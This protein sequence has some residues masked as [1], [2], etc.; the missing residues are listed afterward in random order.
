DHTVDSCF[1]GREIRLFLREWRLAR[2]LDFNCRERIQLRG[3]IILPGTA[4][5]LTD[6]GEVLLRQLDQRFRRRALRPANDEIHESLEALLCALVNPQ[7]PLKNRV[8]ANDAGK[9]LFHSLAI[10]PKDVEECE[11][12][13]FVLPHERFQR[14]RALVSPGSAQGLDPDALPEGHSF[15]LVHSAPPSGTGRLT[16]A[17]SSKSASTRAR[18]QRRQVR[19]DTTAPALAR[20][21]CPP[22][23]PEPVAATPRAPRSPRGASREP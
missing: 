8:S 18:S 7:Q 19:T 23:L 1:G 15:K 10:R 2:I 14:R 20:P 13:V 16:E 9:D 17:A 12:V 6:F 3:E 5:N 4:G 22:H 21:R 11:Q